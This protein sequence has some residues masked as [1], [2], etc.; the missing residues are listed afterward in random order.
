ML[1]V[2]KKNVKGAASLSL[3]RKETGDALDLLHLF[4]HC[5]A[6]ASCSAEKDAA[7]TSVIRTLEPQ[8]DSS[9]LARALVMRAEH[10]HE[11]GRYQETIMDSRKALSMPVS[12]QVS[13]KA[14][15]LLADAHTASGQFEEAL[16]C[17]QEWMNTDPS[18]KTKIATEIE[19]LRKA[20][21]A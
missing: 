20:L 1:F 19:R 10:Y 11:S 2:A 14:R 6:L 3:I 5:I 16:Q 4:S 21:K 17:L 12:I 13:R 18:F 9:V 7:F 15:R 8:G